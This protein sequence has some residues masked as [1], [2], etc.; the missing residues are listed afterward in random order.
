MIVVFFL[1]RWWYEQQKKEWQQTIALVVVL[2]LADLAKHF[3]LVAVLQTKM[4]FYG[5]IIATKERIGARLDVHLHG[6]TGRVVASKLLHLLQPV[7][8]LLIIW[9][10]LVKC[11]LEVLLCVLVRWI[12]SDVVAKTHHLVQ[13]VVH[14]LH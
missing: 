13:A 1:T 11:E 2:E 9:V 3:N 14:L 12:H 7:L 5:S 6:K 8:C 4:L 10:H